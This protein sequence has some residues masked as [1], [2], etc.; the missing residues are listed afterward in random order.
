MNYSHDIKLRQDDDNIFD[1]H[2]TPDGDF[3]VDD[4]FDINIIMSLFVDALADESEVSE[5][6]RR[7]GFVGDLLLFENEPDEFSGSKLWLVNGRNTTKQLNNTIDFSRD[8]LAWFVKDNLVKNID[9]TGDLHLNGINLDINFI[10]EDNA[11]KE[12]NI[13]LWQNGVVETIE[14]L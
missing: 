3:E 1:I 7:R 5:P 11:V 2:I 13:K 8:G 9:I 14:R 6:L 12:Y 4:T 10:V